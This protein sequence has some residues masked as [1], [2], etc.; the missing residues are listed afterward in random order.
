MLAVPLQTKYK[1]VFPKQEVSKKILILCTEKSHMEMANGRIFL[2]GNHPTE[3]FVPLKHLDDIGVSFDFVTLS[4]A[5][6]ALEKWALP[7][8][9]SVIMNFFQEN[10]V[11]LDNPCKIDQALKNKDSYDG[12]FIP[13]GHGAMLDLP[14]SNEVGELLGYFMDSNK[15]IF[16]LCHGPAA[17]LALGDKLQGLT[18]VAFPDWMD[19][20]TPNLG[21]LPGNMPWF[22]GEKLK[23]KGA[24]VLF[25]LANGRC[26]Q[27]RNIL[28]GDSPD[29]A[30][31]FGG[32]M[33]IYITKN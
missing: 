21:Y 1:K 2:T 16:S 27:D 24:K 23:Q 33:G 20:F 31:R 11:K 7:T 29:A 14:F 3:L 28:T 25:S 22:L 5:P 8:N 30:Q 9:D 32:R 15:G 4:G 18:L 12:V 19:K 13:G 26:H 6:V 10:K 17:L